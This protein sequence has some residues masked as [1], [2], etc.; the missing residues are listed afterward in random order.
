MNYIK[1][2]PPTPEEC[3]TWDRLRARWLFSEVHV[4]DYQMVGWRGPLP[5]Y[6]FRCGCGQ[7]HVNYRQGF[8]NELRCTR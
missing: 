1:R 2:Q 7:L 5:F 4:G 3:S 6:L 8:N